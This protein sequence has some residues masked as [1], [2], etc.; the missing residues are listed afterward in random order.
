MLPTYIITSLYTRLA[1][2]IREQQPLAS[3]VPSLIRVALHSPPAQRVPL[4]VCT[5]VVS[6]PV[7]SASRIVCQ[8]V[9]LG[10]H[11]LCGSPQPPSMR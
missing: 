10:R 1:A 2:P 5:R 4:P 11:G 7:R 6:A 8:G 3:R 9:L